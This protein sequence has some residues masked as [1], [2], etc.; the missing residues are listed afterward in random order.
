M[1][2]TT[3]RHNMVKLSRGEKLDHADLALSRRNSAYAV[4]LAKAATARL[5]EATGGLGVYKP[6]YLQRAF[7]DVQVISGHIALGWDASATIY[8]RHAVGLSFA[9]I[10]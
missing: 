9:D 10:V 8:G 6:E 3:A 7:R 5:F 4:R 1:A 2:L